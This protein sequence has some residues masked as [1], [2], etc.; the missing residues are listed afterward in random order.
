MLLR[1][2]AQMDQRAATAGTRVRPDG[3]LFSLEPDCSKPMPADYVTKRVAI[4]KD[5]LGIADKRS[6]TIELEDQALALFR[7]EGQQRPVGRRGP[8]PKGAMSYEEIGRRLSRTGR[9]ASLAIAAAERREKTA[10]LG[11]VDV[12]DGSILGLRKFTS[13]ELLDSGLNIA[14]VA[15]RQGHGPQVLAKHYAK[16]RRSADRQAAEHLGRLIHRSPPSAEPPSL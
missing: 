14:A 8:P 12:F 9:W 6:A 3:Y 1:H 4:L 15:E 13:S 7:G 16:G 10:A 11:G 2:I 5:H